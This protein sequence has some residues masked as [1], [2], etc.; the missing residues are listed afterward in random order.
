VFFLQCHY[1][2]VCIFTW[3][4]SVRSPLWHLPQEPF[5][6]ELSHML[7]NFPSLS[8]VPLRRLPFCLARCGCRIFSSFCSDNAPWG[9]Y[10]YIT[11]PHL[12]FT[13]FTEFTTK[14]LQLRSV[15]ASTLTHAVTITE[16][17][18]RQWLQLQTVTW[19]HQELW[20]LETISRHWKCTSH[21]IFGNDATLT[22]RKRKETYAGSE[23]HSPHQL[24]KRS[25]F[26]TTVTM[27][28]MGVDLQPSCLAD[29]LLT[30]LGQP[31]INP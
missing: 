5:C 19:T 3:L 14:G 31:Q 23:S 6:N 18:R 30:G 8:L 9:I 12:T 24:R 10:S 13:R 15:A 17:R 1:Q 4:A 7:S 25:H 27:I 2:T 28:T 21:I 26:V 11:L 16:V 20:L 29:R 22:P